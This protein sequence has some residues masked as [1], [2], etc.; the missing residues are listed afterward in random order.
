MKFY[1]IMLGMFSGGFLCALCV[2]SFSWIVIYNSDPGTGVEVPVLPWA[3]L[4]A[5]LGATIGFLIGV[6]LGL[7]IS[8]LKG[9]SIA[10]TFLGLFA[11]LVLVVWGSQTSGSPDIIYPTIPLLI[12]FLPACALSG[13]LTSLVVKALSL[14][15]SAKD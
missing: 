10:G 2:A 15:E 14:E 3:N 13:C 7:V 12:S 6:P 4:A 1:R 8:V 9:G 5:V 11:G